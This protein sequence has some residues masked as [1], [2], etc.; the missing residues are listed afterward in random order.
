MLRRTFVFFVSLAAAGALL[1]AVAVADGP[2]IAVMPIAADGINPSFTATFDAGK[3]LTDLLTNKLVDTG[4]LTVVDRVNIEK[5][6]AEQK[7]AQ[8][9][10]LSSANAVQ[11]GHT[12]G[13]NFLIVGRI[14]YLDKAGSNSGVASQALSHFGLGGV[15]TSADKIKLDVRL[16]LVDASTG[17]IVKAYSHEES[18]STQGFSLG[19]LAPAG[20]GGYSSQSF[21]SSI[22]GQLLINAANDFAKKISDTPMTV[23]P[24]GPT[25]NALIIALDGTNAILNKGSADGVTV[26]MFF[27]VFHQ[28]SARDPSTNQTLVTD[29]PDG[30][31]QVISVGEHSCVARTVTGKPAAPGI[32][33]SS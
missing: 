6:F 22:I 1:P 17:R 13:A 27:S 14:V 15:T 25:I 30:T 2:S 19:D 21:A 28:V 5:V 7:L 11:L 24:S 3:A 26:G 32:A 16:Q 8:S 18:R 31:V 9:A 20:L 23:A 10:D 29:I 12:I 4:K 33:R